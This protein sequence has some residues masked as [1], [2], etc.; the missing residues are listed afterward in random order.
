MLEEICLPLDDAGGDLEQGFVADLEAANEPARLLQLGAQHRVIAVAAKQLGVLLVDRQLG[1]AGGADLDLPAIVHLANE[2]IG[3]DILRGGRTDGLAGP[4]IAAADQCKRVVQS[5]LRC[6]QAAAQLAILTR[7]N[8]VEVVFREFEREFQARR[9]RI[10]LLQLQRNAFRQRA[11]ADARR[12]EPLYFCE[13]C[14]DLIITHAGFG[15]EIVTDLIEPDRQIT[16]IA[17]CVDDCFTD[18]RFPRR[19]LLHFELPEQVFA[20]GLPGLVGKLTDRTAFAVPAAVL[21]LALGASLPLVFCADGFD[22]GRRFVAR[23]R[24]VRQVLHLQHDVLF[25]RI[26]DLGVQVENG[27]LQQ[28][29]RLLQLRRHCECLTEF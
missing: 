11:G 7:G 5:L 14:L 23:L 29:D 9:C 20:K 8:E 13:H 25:E 26:L 15:L 4:W 2:H 17:D 16:V 28:A 27:Q 19:D 3:D 24:D 18:Q 1:H 22:L 6:P 12:I 21:D 10:E